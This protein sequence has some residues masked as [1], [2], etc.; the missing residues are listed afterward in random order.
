M[1]PL[2]KGLNRAC[3]CRPKKVELIQ[4]KKLS[5]VYCIIGVSSYYDH[6]HCEP[7]T[8]NISSSMYCYVLILSL[9]IYPLVPY[10]RERTA[11]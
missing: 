11:A 9:Y 2:I 10:C 5:Y 3:T 1:R 6:F 8:N 7:D 4:N